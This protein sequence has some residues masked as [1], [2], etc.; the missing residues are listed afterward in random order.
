MRDKGIPRQAGSIYG[1]WSDDIFAFGHAAW[2]RH[3]V[4]VQLADSLEIQ[5]LASI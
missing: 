1:D 2:F 3:I 4:L 5:V